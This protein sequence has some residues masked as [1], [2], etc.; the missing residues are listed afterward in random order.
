MKKNL[1]IILFVLLAS[2]LAGCGDDDSNKTDVFANLRGNNSSEWAEATQKAASIIIGK[3]EL[4][5]DG[6]AQ[7]RVDGYNSFAEFSLDGVVKYEKNV[8]E[9]SYSVTSTQFTIENDWVYDKSGRL[10]GHIKSSAFGYN[11]YFLCTIGDPTTDHLYIYPDEGQDIRYLV[12][13]G[14]GFK[15]LK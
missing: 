4:V 1:T 10:T 11:G 5:Y 2:V 14:V 3:W 9:D 6:A 7:E 8:G 12:D 15:K 13:P